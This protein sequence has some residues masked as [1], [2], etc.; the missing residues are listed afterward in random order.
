VASPI[1]FSAN[2]PEETFALGQGIAAHLR[3]GSVIALRGELG[4]GKTCLVKGIAS[5]LGIED[6]ITSPT[7]TII[8]EYSVPEGISR[9][10][11]LRHMDIYRISG[12]EF[13]E[14]GGEELIRGD[15]ISLIEWSE[16][17]EKYLPENTIRIYI[18]ITGSLSRL[19]NIEGINIL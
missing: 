4:S 19:I 6:T 7:Y 9:N 3:P 11:I 1:E 5:G 14:I 13:I 10:Q 2:S 12:E 8:N 18:K 16:R 15:D 17:V